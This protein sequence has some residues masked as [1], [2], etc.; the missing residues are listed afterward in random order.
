[1]NIPPFYR[2]HPAT[3]ACNDF[4][5]AAGDCFPQGRFLRFTSIWML[6]KDG[7][8]VH[9]F[10]RGTVQEEVRLGNMIHDFHTTTIGLLGLPAYKTYA[11]QHSMS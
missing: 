9:I 7:Q 3:K 4:L 10:T 8:W 11:Y 6:G 5:E 2:E 1:M